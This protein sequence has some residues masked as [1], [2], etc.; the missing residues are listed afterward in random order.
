[1]TKM[2]CKVQSILSIIFSFFFFSVFPFYFNKF[3]GGERL[4][5]GC[6]QSKAPNMSFTVMFTSSA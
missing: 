3:Q 6:F 4:R 2:R 1:M 5:G